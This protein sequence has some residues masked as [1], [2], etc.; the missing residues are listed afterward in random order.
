VT[1]LSGLGFSLYPLLR[2][3]RRP[4]WRSWPHLLLLLGFTVLGFQLMVYS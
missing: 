3:T 4:W 1:L 2:I